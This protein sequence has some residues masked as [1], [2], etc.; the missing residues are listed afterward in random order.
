MN[1]KELQT[2]NNIPLVANEGDPRIPK[3]MIVFFKTLFPM[4]TSVA[5]PY[6]Q[7]I[8]HLITLFMVDCYL[9]IFDK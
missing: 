8:H 6:S 5:N 7:S 9:I 4:A 2:Q 1:I 3:I